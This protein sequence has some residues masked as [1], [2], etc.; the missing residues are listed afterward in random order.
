MPFFPVAPSGLINSRKS[1]HVFSYK[2]LDFIGAPLANM[3]L[4]LLFLQDDIEEDASKI[5]GNCDREAGI[6]EAGAGEA[7]GDEAGAGEACGDG[8]GAE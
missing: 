7:C 6:D 8:A 3:S 2:C 5:R 4:A 1:F